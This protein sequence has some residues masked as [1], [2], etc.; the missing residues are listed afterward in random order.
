MDENKFRCT[1]VWNG[2]K[3]DRVIEAESEGD[4]MDHWM[5]WA[6]VAKASL[7]NLQVNRVA[8]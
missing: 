3:F 8:N 5:F 1:G 6:W 2:E 4:A 7:E